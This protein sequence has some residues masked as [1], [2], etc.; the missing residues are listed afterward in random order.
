MDNFVVLCYMACLIL[1][2]TG[3]V[4]GFF[5]GVFSKLLYENIT[6]LISEAIEKL[7]TISCRS[8]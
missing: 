4:F 3:M 8:K 6:L 7:R 1:Y 2:L 5:L